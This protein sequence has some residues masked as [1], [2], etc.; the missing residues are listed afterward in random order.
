MNNRVKIQYTQSVANRPASTQSLFCLCPQQRSR[1]T[2][3]IPL[4]RNTQ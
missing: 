4:E 3:A 1:L 2:T